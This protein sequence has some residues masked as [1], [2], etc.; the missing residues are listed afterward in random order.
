MGYYLVGYV[1]SRYV[2]RQTT[3]EHGWSEGATRATAVEPWL[4]ADDEWQGQGHGEIPVSK[5]V[6][7]YR[8]PNPRHV[9]SPGDS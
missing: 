9:L 8:N 6:E 7:H 1:T 4:R 3:C 2:V 5:D